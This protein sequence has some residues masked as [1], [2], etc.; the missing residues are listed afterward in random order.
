MN[1][2]DSPCVWSVAQKVT[3]PSR[4]Q[5]L[6]L[7][8]FSARPPHFSKKSHCEEAPALNKERVFLSF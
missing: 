7:L 8:D 6:L 3:M 1:G 4:Q 5:P 2:W